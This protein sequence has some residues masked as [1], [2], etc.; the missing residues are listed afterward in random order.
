MIRLIIDIINKKREK[1]E[2]TKEE[3]EMAFMGYLKGKIADYQ[4]SALLMA[5]CCNG[6]SE[7][8]T[9]DLV[10]I[11]IHSGKILDF[12]RFTFNPCG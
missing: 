1:K 5:I 12:R 10:D 8:E 6:M 9:F 3:L 4:M 7:Q 2:L 11:F